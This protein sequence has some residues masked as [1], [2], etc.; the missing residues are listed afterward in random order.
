VSSVSST[1]AIVK[2]NCAPAAASPGLA[3]F[4]PPP[5]PAEI[6][7]ATVAD[8]LRLFREPGDVTEL[9]ALGVKQRYGRPQTVSG[10]F[11]YDHLDVMAA[12]ALG[13]TGDAQ[14][15]YFTMNPLKPEILARRANRVDVAKEGELAAD[16]DVAR[17]CWLLVDADPVRLSGISATDGEKELA[18]SVIWDVHDY[19][20][21]CGW[22]RPIVADSGN[23]FHVLFRI[24]LC[25]ADGGIVQR[26]L[27]ALAAQFDTDGVK[28]DT[29]VHNP[30]RITKLYGTWA[31]KG[32]STPDRPHRL[33]RVLEVP[34]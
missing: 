6:N 19:L 33:A 27:T 34:E 16:G 7:T 29:A 31:R 24:D 9:R 3:L 15:V 26:V 2:P 28:I 17:R 4:K 11:D 13:L 25:A 10:F 30:A 32:D 5:D 1:S 20:S 21:A 14:G 8:W 22:T 23:G 18:R 12:A